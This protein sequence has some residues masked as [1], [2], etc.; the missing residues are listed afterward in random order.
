MKNYLKSLAVTALLL[1]CA[2]LPSMAQVVSVSPIPQEISW[3]GSVAFSS[4]ASFNLVGDADADA[5]ALFEDNFATGGA[6]QVLI[7]E[8]GDAA[9]AAYESFIPEKPE[10]YYLSVSSDKVVIAGNDG[11]G[12]FYGVQ[13]FIQIASQPEVMAVTVTDYP[14]VP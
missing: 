12:T 14:S 8:R 9:I 1:L 4:S 10:G 7:G 2:A 3:E 6:L 5:V 13:T 11:A